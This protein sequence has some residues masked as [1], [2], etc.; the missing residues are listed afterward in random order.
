MDLHSEILDMWP[1]RGP[2]SFNFVTFFENLVS[3][4]LVLPLEGWCP[5][6]EE[7]MDLTLLVLEGFPYF[8]PPL[9][10]GCLCF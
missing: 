3:H 6:L 5:H 9:L 7:I 10:E 4:M 1:P 8:R 2:N